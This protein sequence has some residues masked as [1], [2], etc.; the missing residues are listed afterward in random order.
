MKRLHLLVDVIAGGQKAVPVCACRD[1][2]LP[3]VHCLMCS[4]IS[5]GL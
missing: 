1:W 2:I 5:V 4:V 3:S